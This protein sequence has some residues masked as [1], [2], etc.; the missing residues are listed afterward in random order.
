MPK[1]YL[2]SHNL[3]SENMQDIIRKTTIRIK[4]EGDKPHVTM[5]RQLE[6]LEQLHQFDFGQFLLQNHGINGYWTHYML[7]HPWFGQKTGNNNRGEPFTQLERFFL[8]QAPTI[9]ATQQ[10]FKIFLK[11]NQKMVKNNKVLACIPCGMMGE[12]LYLNFK[13]IKTI[14]QPPQSETV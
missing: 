10:R 3:T 5:A 9:L 1:K 11:E 13:N 6:L 8:E 7:T 14:C 12:L 2:H 4:Q